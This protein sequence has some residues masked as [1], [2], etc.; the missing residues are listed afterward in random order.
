MT[1]KLI[2]ALRVV[3][4]DEVRV[5]VSSLVASIKRDGSAEDGL[6]CAARLARCYVILNNNASWAA[7]VAISAALV[8]QGTAVDSAAAVSSA[9]KQATE[10][11][12]ELG[13]ELGVGW[14]RRDDAR[15]LA[16]MEALSRFYLSDIRG[17][18]VDQAGGLRYVGHLLQQRGMAHPSVS[19]RCDGDL[20]QPSPLSPVLLPLDYDTGPAGKRTSCVRS[21]APTSASSSD[22]ARCCVCLSMSPRRRIRR[23]R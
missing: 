5:A 4:V 13:L 15:F 9:Q 22:G 2:A 10:C 17:A 14:G 18:I 21:S 12:L 20:S 23:T 19:M 11:E 7:G 8:A 16:A 1:D 6:S 3:T